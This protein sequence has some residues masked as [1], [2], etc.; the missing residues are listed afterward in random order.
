MAIH[1]RCALSGLL[2]CL[3]MWQP[4]LAA[5]I[6]EFRLSDIEQNIR[7][8]ETTVREQARQIAE[9]QRQPGN[10]LLPPASSNIGSNN[11]EARWLSISNWNRV[12]PGMS[13]LQVIELL[14]APS[15]Q[16]VSDDKR[17]RTLLYAMEIGRSGFLTG[18]VALNDG[19]AI[20]IEIPSLK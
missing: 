18:S 17:T 6:D 19:K 9:L 20:R 12:K 4:L 8:L 1:I 14:G 15:Q 7:N 3:G 13:E 11:N 10:K 5:P 16:R 2:L